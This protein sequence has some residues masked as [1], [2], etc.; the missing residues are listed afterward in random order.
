MQAHRRTHTLS[1]EVATVLVLCGK[2]TGSALARLEFSCMPST[3]NL[4]EVEWTAA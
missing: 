3:V 2:H 4:A 1:C